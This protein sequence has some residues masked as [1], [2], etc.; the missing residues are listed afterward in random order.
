MTQKR[1]RGEEKIN[2]GKNSKG[3]GGYWNLEQY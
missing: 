1:M 2:I 3:F